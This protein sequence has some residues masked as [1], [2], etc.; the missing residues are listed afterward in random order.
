[1]G[2]FLPAFGN[3]EVD[4]GVSW[5]LH[6]SS[7]SSLALQEMQVKGLM[8]VCLESSAWCLLLTQLVFTG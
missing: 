3:T 6:R 7:V 1:M 8:H 2:L 5:S 4:S